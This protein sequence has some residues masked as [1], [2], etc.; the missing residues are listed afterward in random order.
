MKQS[1]L[2]KLKHH[3]PR[4][5]FLLPLLFAHIVVLAVYSSDQ[6]RMLE[7]EANAQEPKPTDIREIKPGQV[8]QRELK[9]AESHSYTVTLKAG[10]YMVLAVESSSIDFAMRALDSTGNAI[11]EI[12]QGDRGPTDSLWA[13]ARTAGDYQIKITAVEGKEALGR[14]IIRLEKV[15]ELETAS[16]A[17]QTYVRAHKLFREGN[18][19]CDQGGDQD[20]RQATVKYLEVL[21][22][23][24]TLGDRLGEASTLH[25]LGYIY[26]RLG[27]SQ[28]AV[29]LYEQALPL[30]RT[31]KNHQQNEATTLYNLGGNYAFSGR[32]TEAMKCYE[33]AIEL[34]R[35]FGNKGSLAY[36]LNNLGQVYINIGDFQAALKCHQEALRLRIDVGDVEGQARSLSN[37][38]GVY[39]YLGEFQEALN[40]CKQALP[41]RRA[42]GDRKGEAITLT[43]IGSNYRELGEPQRAL[44]YY[45]QAVSFMSEQSDRIS[46]ASVLDALGQTY[47]ELGDYPKALRC[48]TRS[49]SLRQTMDDRY[50]EGSSLANL[51]NAY[52]GMGDRQK[53][54]EYLEQSLKVR[55]AIGDRRGQALT[56][57]NAGELYRELGDWQR[58]LAYFNDGLAISR[59]IKNRFV[60]ANLLYDMARIGQSAG[61]LIE[62]RS[63]VESAIAIIESTRAK[64]ASADLRASFFA[65]KQDFYELDIDLLMQSYRGERDQE[66]LVK[67]FSVSEQRRARSLLDSLEGPRVRIS[68]GLSPE[69]LAHERELRARL[70]QKAESQIKLLSG[71]YTP[72]EASALAKA[73]DSIATDYEQLLTEIRATSPLYASL[74]QPAPLSLRDIQTNI[75]DADTLLLEYSLG[76][77][78]SYLWAVTSTDITAYELPSRAEIESQARNIYGLLTSRDRFVKF[79]KPDERQ[80]RIAKADAEY[81]Q[82]SSRLSQLLLG[83]LAANLKGKRLLIVSDGALQYLPFAAL[84]TPVTSTANE[85][86]QTIRRAYRPLIVDHEVTSLPSASILGVLRREVTGRKPAPKTVAVLADPVFRKTDER[87]I[88][89]ESDR[90][91]GHQRAKSAAPVPVKVGLETESV[92][93]GLGESGL[94]IDRLPST[95]QEARAILDLVPRAD[96]FEALDFHANRLAATS[97]ELSQYRFV[98]FA[99]HGLLNSS[100]PGLSGLIFSLVDRQGNDQDGFLSAHEVF[101]LNLPVDLVVLSGCRTGLGKEIKGEGML[102]LTRG[103]MYAGAARVA[104]SLW[105]VNDMSTAELMKHFYGGMLGKESLSPGA[106]LRDAQVAMWKSSRWHAPYYWA[107]F[108]LQGEYR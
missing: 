30:W 78:R 88:A 6:A 37:I 14:Y 64:V 51:G 107:A 75:L 49:L 82:A 24:R 1:F 12:T 33:K 5:R 105:D 43:N 61:H 90:K 40:Y 86:E 106:A 23:W 41:L 4:L 91:A 102:G 11:A 62:A 108:V 74:T 18:V 7:S 53:A 47:S 71:K 99:T 69:L 56:L 70:N 95:R 46:E 10:E 65:S 84:P 100:H 29:E 58:A 17:D 93:D 19:F 79:E 67:A 55:R 3:Q 104:V 92:W 85:R 8:I 22:L 34:R 32:V 77:E 31:V 26:T 42:A 35:R 36:A 20:L 50:G 57:K 44:E 13:H 38:S 54:L 52:A 103:F 27:D 39:F 101:D 73:V 59:A 66:S 21:K 16:A 63:Q 48:L 87:V 28:K 68:R 15:A 96:R 80:A 81:F 76:K 9:G 72:E 2:M 60:E 25:M 45:Q 89:A 98:H 83:P 94:E 97:P